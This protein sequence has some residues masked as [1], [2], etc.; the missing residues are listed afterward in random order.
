MTLQTHKRK[1]MGS[2]KNSTL[3]AW[4]SHNTCVPIQHARYL[5][6]EGHDQDK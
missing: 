3:Y 1:K 4:L 6:T 2:P 5:N